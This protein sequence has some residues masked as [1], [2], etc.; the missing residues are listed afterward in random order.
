L[1]ITVATTTLSFNC[2]PCAE[3]DGQNPKRGVAV[4]EVSLCYRQRASGRRR[5][6]SHAEIG[7]SLS[8]L[9]VAQ[10]LDMKRA[11]VAIDVSTVG[12]ALIAITR[13][14]DVQTMPEPDAE[15]APLAQ[16]T[17]IVRPLSFNPFQSR[18]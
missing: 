17:T 6:Q 3:D 12:L 16:S 14:R 1:L 4:N 5:H 10:R 7:P 8:Q 11:A 9:F 18:R 2:D 15:L 13:R